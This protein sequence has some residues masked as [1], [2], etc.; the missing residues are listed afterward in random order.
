MNPYYKAFEDRFVVGWY[1]MALFGDGNSRSTYEI[2]L[3][4]GTNNILLNYGDVSS[5]GRFFT[6]GIRGDDAAEYEVIYS[7]TDGNYMDFRS[8][9]LSP[10]SPP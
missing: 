6:A 2:T 9:L 1:N 8:W 5:G 7:G 4:S 10:G 3:F